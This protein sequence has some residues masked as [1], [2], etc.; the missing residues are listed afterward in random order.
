MRFVCLSVMAT[1]LLVPSFASAGDDS[2]LK[3]GDL[4]WVQNMLCNA[5]DAYEL[6][7]VEAG[8]YAGKPR[9]N[10]AQDRA[11]AKIEEASRL[12]ERLRRMVDRFVTESQE[13]WKKTKDVAKKL[14]IESQIAEAKA[15]PDEDC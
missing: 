1:F 3:I 12:K 2:E 13:R 10:E 4:L 6:A 5:E 8:T 15:L 7:K 11:A 14:K 9:G